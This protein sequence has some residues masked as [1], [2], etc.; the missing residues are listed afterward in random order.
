MTWI[1]Y[2]RAW[3]NAAR[4]DSCDA[5]GFVCWHI[6]AAGLVF[7]AVLQAVLG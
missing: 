6:I 5:I 3:R 7:A 4:Q 1:N 2:T